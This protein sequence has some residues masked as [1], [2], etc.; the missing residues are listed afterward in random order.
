V[1]TAKYVGYG[2]ALLGACVFAYTLFLIGEVCLD[3]LYSRA[4]SAWNGGSDVIFFFLVLAAVAVLGAA[5][6]K[7]GLWMARAGTPEA[8]QSALNLAGLAI[9]LSVII[10]ASWGLRGYLDRLRWACAGILGL[11]WL[12]IAV[13]NAGIAWQGLVRREKNVPSMILFVGGIL[14]LFAVHIIPRR[15]DEL[16]WL[17]RLAVIFLDAGSAPFLLIGAALI[18][19]GL[20]RRKLRRS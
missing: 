7:W 11:A 16:K 1:R 10:G 14:G 8:E 18:A 6:A 5:L 20:I 19:A 17:L 9:F 3:L 12:S 4:P 13:I 2:V 15:Y